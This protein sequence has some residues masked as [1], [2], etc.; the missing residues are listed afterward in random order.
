ML[1]RHPSYAESAASADATI[2]AENG[3][4]WALE[5]ISDGTNAVVVKAFDGPPAN[6]KLIGHVEVTGAGKFAYV[7]CFGVHF[8]TGLH[9]VVTGTGSAGGA[10]YSK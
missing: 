2:L 6:N 5:A 3:Q 10:Y 9:L 8:T 7:Q 4:L 1:D